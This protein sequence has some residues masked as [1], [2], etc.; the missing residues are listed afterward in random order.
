MDPGEQDLTIEGD[1][2]V[3]E[4]L[5]R[6][7][8]EELGTDANL[9]AVPSRD[10]DELR[11][12]LIIALIVSLGGPTIVKGIVSILKRRYDHRE[13]IER[14]RAELRIAEMAHERDMTALTLKAGEDAGDRVVTEDE[15]ARWAS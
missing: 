11:E 7:I 2:A 3:L 12:P 5:R 4:W 8:E 14:I 1:P 9:E 15:L 6:C 13:E 10:A